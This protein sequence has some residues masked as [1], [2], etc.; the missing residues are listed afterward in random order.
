MMSMLTWIFPFIRIF[1]FHKA[2]RRKNEVWKHLY[3]L[4]NSENMDNVL[5]SFTL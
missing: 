5:T 2:E 4:P 3:L 1:M